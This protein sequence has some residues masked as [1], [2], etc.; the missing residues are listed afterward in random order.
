MTKKVWLEDEVMLDEK[1]KITI[2]VRGSIYIS[3]GS[4]YGSGA[5]IPIDRWHEVK[6]KID[7]MISIRNAEIGTN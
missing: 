3:N 6:T 2:T 5:D 1:D 7:E 4:I